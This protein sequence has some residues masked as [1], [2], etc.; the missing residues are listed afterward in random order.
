[1][2]IGA[3]VKIGGGGSL[4]VDGVKMQEVSTLT[5]T[6]FN[7]TGNGII[8][9]HAVEFG[10]LGSGGLSHVFA[11]QGGIV[12]LLQNYT[13]SGSASRHLRTVQLGQIFAAG[14]TVTLTGTPAFGTAYV[15]A[16]NLARPGVNGCTFSGSATGTRHLADA[17]A[18]IFTNGG[19]AT[20]LPGNSSG[21][22]TNGGRYM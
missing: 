21:S 16:T 9:V 11:E 18:V 17:L 7:A 3:T 6:S 13:I 22:E 19:G 2:V 1:M 15:Q 14:L 10:D 4:I 8:E 12:R 5:V 20:Y